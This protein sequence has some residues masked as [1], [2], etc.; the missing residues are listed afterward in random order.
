MVLTMK[1]KK[2]FLRVLEGNNLYTIKAKYE[3]LNRIATHKKWRHEP[4]RFEIDPDHVFKSGHDLTVF[5]ENTSKRSIGIKTDGTIDRKQETT[6]NL[7]IDKA[8]WKA[9]IEKRKVS[10]STIIVTLLAGMGL[11][12]LLITTLRVFGFQV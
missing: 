3:P 6:L 7:L 8:F 4:Q 2:I 12:L 5:I 1:D 11:Y 9:L 10:T